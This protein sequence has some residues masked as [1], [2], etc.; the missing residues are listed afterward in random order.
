MMA[1]LI[2]FSKVITETIID[3]SNVVTV[4][5]AGDGSWLGS[6]HQNISSITDYYSNQEETWK[7]YLFEMGAMKQFALTS[8]GFIL[9][10]VMFAS[11]M[12]VALL[13]LVRLVGLWALTMFSPIGYALAILP[14][15][16][17][18]GKKWWNMFIQYLIWAPVSLFL[19]RAGAVI[20]SEGSV[21]NRFTGQ[22]SI[23]FFLLVMTFF[24]LAVTVAKKSGMA[25][26]DAVLK[27]ADKAKG[28]GL[29][30]GMG[31]TRLGA[32]K[33]GKK[34]RVQLL[35]S[36]W[37]KQW[38]EYSQKKEHEDIED[39]IHAAQ[40]AAAAGK[41]FTSFASPEDLYRKVG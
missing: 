23:F 11:Y 27:W 4:T 13:L 15:T 16:K 31:L 20:L 2:N 32:R 19:L 22:N 24:W 29:K 7:D 9:S 3:I 37:V 12:A 41:R 34:M 36:V 10:V 14:A 28:W 26:A 5:F 17:D 38:K 39:T 8:T 35:P 30:G 6:Y 18:Y 40:H 21:R 1:L 33:L 25:G